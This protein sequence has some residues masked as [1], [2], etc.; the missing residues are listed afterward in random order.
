MRGDRAD[1]DV[2]A[3]GDRALVVAIRCGSS[4]AVHEFVMRFRPMLVLAARRLGLAAGEREEI[5]DDV[6][7]DTAIRFTDVAAPI[8]TGVR[9]YLLRSLRNRATNA[10]R[11]R[12]RRSRATAAATD[13]ACDAEPYFEQAVVGCASEHSVRAS[14]G[15]AWD[16]LAVAPGLARLAMLLSAT[17]SVEE[18]TLVEWLAHHVPQQEIAAWLGIGYDATSKRIRRLRARLQAAGVR[19]AEHLN[20]AER[21][22]VMIFLRRASAVALGD[23]GPTPAR[24]RARDV[25][26]AP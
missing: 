15:P 3:L 16:G 12:D 24:R 13:R 4:A 5:A 26:R 6:L 25:T 20:A 7:H 17:L 10:R 22:E 21:N 23:P 8:P 19:H 11:A 14:H 9:G 1:R 18:R 2:D